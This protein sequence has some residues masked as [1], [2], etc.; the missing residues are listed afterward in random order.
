MAEVYKF[1]DAGMKRLFRAAYP[2]L[3]VPDVFNRSDFDW[4]NLEHLADRLEELGFVE[5]IYA[6]KKEAEKLAIAHRMANDHEYRS[7]VDSARRYQ[8]RKNRLRE[9]SKKRSMA[10]SERLKSLSDI[11]CKEISYL[12]EQISLAD[13]EKYVIK[14]P[15]LRAKYG[16]YL[17]SALSRDLGVLGIMAE[18]RNRGISMA[19]KRKYAEDPAFAKEIN[20]R[21]EKAR[22]AARNSVRKTKSNTH[23]RSALQRRLEKAS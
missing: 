10:Y 19:M 21:M 11:L 12:P 22:K 13:A 23:K 7:R 3:I 6:T 16:K 15:D 9:A 8:L 14:Y 5:R 18:P 2:S 20:R 17:R 1:R 4:Y